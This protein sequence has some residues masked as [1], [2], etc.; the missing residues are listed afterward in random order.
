MAD[1]HVL[2]AMRLE[3]SSLSLVN[4]SV[5]KSSACLC[6][7]PDQARP[8]LRH[9]ETLQASV[10]GVVMGR[11]R[12]V[13]NFPQDA[14]H[15]SSGRRRGQNIVSDALPAPKGVPA[16]M[17]FEPP[18]SVERPVSTREPTSLGVI[19]EGSICLG[20]SEDSTLIKYEGKLHTASWKQKKREGVV[21]SEVVRP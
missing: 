8:R 20:K 12:Q 18:E 11:A 19:F 13:K 16:S 10:R 9:L 21:A 2:D 14:D 1:A 4:G 5:D 7:P 17:Q 3:L 6:V 15:V